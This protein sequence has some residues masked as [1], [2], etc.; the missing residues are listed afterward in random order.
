MAL[1][2]KIVET[3]NRIVDCQMSPFQ[4]GTLTLCFCLFVLSGFEE[5]MFPGICDPNEDPTRFGSKRIYVETL[6]VTESR[7]QFL[8]LRK[9]RHRSSRQNHWTADQY[10]I[11]HG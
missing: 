2:R 9:V 6:H 10:R 3:S 8:L 7:S 1:F 5:V 11:F 4:W